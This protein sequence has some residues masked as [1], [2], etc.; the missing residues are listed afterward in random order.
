[1]SL[2]LQEA[3]Y[4]VGRTCLVDTVSID[5]EPGTVTVVVGPNGAGKSTLLKLLSGDLYP[6]RGASFLDGERLSGMTAAEL[7]KRRA[8]LPQSSALSFDFRVSDVVA[9]G[10]LPYHEARQS[11]RTEAIVRTAMKRAGC[12]AYADRTYMTLSGGERQRVHFARI[13]AQADTTGQRANPP[14]RRA[15]PYVLL[16]EP[17]NALDLVHQLSILKTCRQLAD[18]GAGV[19]MILHDFNL[20]LNVADHLVVLSKGRVFAAG[21]P[22]EV[23]SPQVVEQVWGIPMAISYDRESGNRWLVPA[24]APHGG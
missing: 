5:V 16:D 19:L 15:N 1:M 21:A 13:L 4:V 12:S 22:W 8:V 18:D 7:A 20:A 11:P 17:T 9:L 2:S 24:V 6:T 3:S 14:G 23:L 10:R